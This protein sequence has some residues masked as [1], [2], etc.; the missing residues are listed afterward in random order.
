MT[1]AILI[2][3]V[4]V[5]VAILLT[6]R[7]RKQVVGICSTAL[8]ATVRKNANKEK[9]AAFLS[10]KR[11]ASNAELREHLGVTDRSVVRYLDEL[12]K[13][14]KVEQVGTAGR[15]VIYRAK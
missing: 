7:T 4:V 2:F 3:I 6:R 12:E 13:E 9:I 11:E 14:G 1:E 10:Q 15:G 8:D 5:I